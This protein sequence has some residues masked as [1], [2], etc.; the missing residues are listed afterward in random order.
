MQICAVDVIPLPCVYANNMGWSH[1]EGSHM[2]ETWHRPY[3]V[4]QLGGS[5]Y[6]YIKH[7]VDLKLWDYCFKSKHLNSVNLM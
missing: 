3:W 5:H 7:G 4:I 6:V 2:L 1:F